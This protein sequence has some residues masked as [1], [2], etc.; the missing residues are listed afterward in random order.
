MIY[1]MQRNLTRILIVI[2][3]ILLIVAG[4]TA[5][6]LFL[7]PKR[8]NVR[9]ETIRNEKI[10][11]SLDNMRICYFTDLDYG[12]FVDEERL[13]EI[14]E[15]IN[16][17]SAD[18]VIFGG[19][20]YEDTVLPD[21]AGNAALIHALSSIEAPYGKFAVYGD[22]D[23]D[24]PEHQADI[25]T[26]YQSSGFEVVN[27]TSLSLHKGGSAS[28]T[29]VGL[30]NGLSAAA[31][32]DSAYANV[33]ANNLVVS[34]CHT[35][36]SADLVPS[37]LTDYMLAG[38]SH[39]GQA[40]FGLIALDTPAMAVRYLSG[41]HI[42]KD[43]F[44]LDISSGVGTTIKNVRFMTANEIVVYRLMHQEINEEEE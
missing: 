1:F 12:L 8:L 34:V 6:A 20:L 25:D 15:K 21:E 14:V 28:I 23:N 31:D 29:L 35:P 26:I 38:H 39:A 4:M 36:D 17:V 44:T 37:D 43:Q 19:D 40:N 16:A 30:N 42:I 41:R 22:H 13:S 2:F 33:S 24:T 9:Q 3:S 11:E 27:D 32:I 5:D 10:P 7:A 18:V